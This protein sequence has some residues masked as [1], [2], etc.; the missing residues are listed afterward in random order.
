MKK[1]LLTI[2]VI[3]V[4][5]CGGGNSSKEGMKDTKMTAKIG[6]ENYEVDVRYQL[7][8]NTG[9]TVYSDKTDVTDSN[10]DGLIFA[11]FEYNGKLQFDF[12]K[13]GERLGGRITDWSKTANDISGNGTLKPE[14]GLGQGISVSFNLRL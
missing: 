4:Y 6:S 5:A 2:I 8:E 10:N 11:I 13:N 12:V 14:S 1:I 3:I 7:D 9:L